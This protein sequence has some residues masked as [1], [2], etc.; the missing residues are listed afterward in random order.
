MLIGVVGLFGRGTNGIIALLVVLEPGA[1]GCRVARETVVTDV[2]V[3]AGIVYALL[4]VEIFA[5]AVTFGV[6]VI[7]CIVGGFCCGV[8]ALGGQGSRLEG[9][10]VAT[11]V[12]LIA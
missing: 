5:D 7:V 10:L 12:L 6:V 8:M 9:V 2:F 3:T 11:V 4:F 1:F